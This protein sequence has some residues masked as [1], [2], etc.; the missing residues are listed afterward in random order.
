MK[1]NYSNAADSQES[2][3]LNSRSLPPLIWA[4]MPQSLDR[5][6]GKSSLSQIAWVL[7]LMGRPCQQR[8]TDETA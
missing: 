5:I 4:V 3:V 8:A 6:A 2:L 7:R 1:P